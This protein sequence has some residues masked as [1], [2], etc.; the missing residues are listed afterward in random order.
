LTPAKKPICAAIIP[1]RGGSKGIPGKNIRPVAGK[2]LIAWAIETALSAT[3]LDRV[4][5]STDSPE[6]AEVARRHGAETP[7]MRPAY[8]AQDDTPGVAPVLHAMRWLMDNE[9]YQPDMV[10]LLQPTSPLRI[11]EDI[12]KAIELAQEKNADAVVSVVLVEAHPYWMKR[13][14][15]EGRI[16]DF[17]KLDNPIVRRQD[18]P[19]LYVVNGAVYVASYEV[20]MEQKTFDTPNTFCLVMP[21]ERSLDIDA[22]WDLYLADLI[23]KDCRKNE[24]G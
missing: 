18:L 15:A 13:R 6:I 4:I 16:A 23:L 24:I 1:A 8:L 14:D 3:S 21:A 17:M 9:G 2:P 11:S 7:F 10:M 19:E 20:L 12:D 5:V 22:P